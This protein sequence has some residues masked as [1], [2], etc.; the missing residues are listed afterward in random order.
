MD[1]DKKYKE[2]K[3]LFWE[4]ASDVVKIAEKFLENYWF[5]MLTMKKSKISFKT[6]IWCLWNWFKWNSYF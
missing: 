1:F 3:S 2:N 4:E 6:V 5:M